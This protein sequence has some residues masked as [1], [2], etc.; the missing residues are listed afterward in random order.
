VTVAKDVKLQVEFNPLRVQA[1]RLIG[2]EHRLLKHQDFNDDK[3]N[4]GVMGAGHT[5]TALYEIVPPGV[6][7]D[8]PGVDPLT[9]QKS[10]Q[11]SE[12][13]FKGDVLTVKARYTLPEESKSRL[14]TVTLQNAATK[15]DEASADFR[16]AA[17][18]FAM[19]LRDSEYKG[20][21]TYGQVLELGRG[22]LGQ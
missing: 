4:A 16:F 1:Y 20:E 14:L 15:V 6:R 8:I 5:V 18:A 7:V 12:E 3:K 21:A 9:Y 11:L 22:A 2:Y 19:L 17:A 10:P 13:A